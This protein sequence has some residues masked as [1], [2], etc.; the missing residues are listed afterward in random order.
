MQSNTT[1]QSNAQQNQMIPTEQS[2][3]TEQSKKQQN[4]Q[5]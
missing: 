4:N 5:T 1:E 3:T 2:K